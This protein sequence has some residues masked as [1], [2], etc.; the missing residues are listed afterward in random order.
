MKNNLFV[1]NL[2][3]ALLVGL[4][5]LP[6]GAAE[7]LFSNYAMNVTGSGNNGELWVFSRSGTYSGVTLLNLNA[8]SSGIQVNGSKQ[9]QASDSMTAMQDGIYSGV[10]AEHRRISSGYAGKIGYVLPMYG[11]D[12][13]G[14]HLLPAGFFSVR[15]TEEVQENP[16]DVDHSLLPEAV[17]EDS[18]MYYAVSGFAFDSTSGRLWLARGAAGLGF[19]EELKS[20][21][22]QGMFQLNLKT[23]AL[24]T[25]KVNY[26]WDAK[27]NPRVLDVKLHPET[28]E[29]WMATSKGL[30]KRSS[31]GKVSKISTSL[32][33]SARVTGLW[34]GGNPLTI[35]AETSYM[36]KESMKGALW[37]LRKNAKDFAKVDFL[38]TAGKQQK[39]DVYDD[40]DYTV[41]GVAFIGKVAYVAVTSGGS[42]SG[43]FR[44][45][46]TGVRAWETDDDGKNNWLYGFETGATDRDAIITSICSFPLDTKTEGLALATYGNGIS[47]SADSGKTWTTILNR[48]KLG[49]DLGTIRMVPSVITSGDGDQSLVS[50]KVSKDS[51]ITIDVFS[52]DMRKIRTIVKDAPRS[53]DKSRSTNPKED[54]WDGKDKAGRPCTMGVYYV[55]VKD[56]HGHIGWGKVMTL[57]GH[58]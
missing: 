31:E 39:K 37:V 38:D 53:A 55:R 46:S 33:T 9:G 58:K 56:N 57:G 25:A 21:K 34:M 44:L 47:V 43:F 10:L 54:F 18:A 32:D 20:G 41:S 23:G 14:N 12:D 1:K 36:Q 27:N 29:L 16:L 26:K 24:D 7:T 51:K 19:Y 6:V 3:A 2:W 11:L 40:G 45:D 52:Y 4:V 8:G 15:G 22:K 49:G 35:I 13:D 42:V 48:A 50:Y 30:W 5:A 28:G 17:A